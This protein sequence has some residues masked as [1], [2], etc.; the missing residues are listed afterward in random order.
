MVLWDKTHTAFMYRAKFWIVYERATYLN[1]AI[2]NEELDRLQ[3][4]LHR[5]TTSKQALS[6]ATQRFNAEK[7]EL[8]RLLK[9][10]LAQNIRE[11]LYT[12]WG[13]NIKSKHKK[14]SL[15]SALFQSG[16]AA[17][18]QQSATALLTIC[19]SHSASILD[20]TSQ[21]ELR[22]ADRIRDNL[23]L[24][25]FSSLSSMQSLNR[26]LQKQQKH[27]RK[28]QLTIRSMTD[29][30]SHKQSVI[31]KQRSKLADLGSTGNHLLSSFQVSPSFKLKYSHPESRE[32]SPELQAVGI[33]R[34]SDAGLL[35]KKKS[36]ISIKPMA[37]RSGSADFEDPEEMMNGRMRSPHNHH[38]KEQR[39]SQSQH[40]AAF[41]SASRRKRAAKQQQNGDH[42]RLQ[43]AETQIVVNGGGNGSAAAVPLSGMDME[44]PSMNEAATSN[45]ISALHRVQDGDRA[46]DGGPEL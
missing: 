2:H 12:S 11:S 29:E 9:E 24:T 46:E 25:V 33:R 14:D 27:N 17:N 1:L 13:I 16:D 42:E 3:G 43:E 35:P 21:V 23:L 38:R 31:I 7:S 19:S 4:L 10:E 41:H 30:L 45:S 28:Q 37:I 40:T 34:Y 22:R 32:A 8:R 6:E 36:L 44:V 20:V 39:T 18:P 15:L 5:L 26:S